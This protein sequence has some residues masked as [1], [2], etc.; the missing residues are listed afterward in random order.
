[1]SSSSA[2]LR[3][4]GIHRNLPTFNESI[5]GLTA[6]ITGANGISGFNTMRALLD[7][8]QRWQTIYGL[9]RRPPPESMMA[10]LS[11]E[12]RSRIKIVTCDFLDGPALI[13]K[14]MKL[15]GVRA[16]YVFYYSY[17]HKDWS[18][19]EALVKSNV[20]LLKNFLEALEVADIRPARFILQTG[21][22]N[23]G[24]Q[25]GRARTPQLESDPQPR[26]L[27]PNFYYPQEDLLKSYCEKQGTSWNVIRPAAVIGASTHAAMNMFYPFAVYAAVQ[28]R[29]G[30]PLFFGGDWEQWQYEYHHCSARMTGYLTEWAA[31]EKHCGNEAFNSN[32]GGPLTYERFFT[33]LASWFGAKGVVPPPD[34]DSKMETIGMGCGGKESPLGYGPPMFG[35]SSFSFLDWANEEENAAAWRDIMMESG[36]KITHDPFEDTESFYM[37]KWAYHR[38]GSVCLNKA[39]R[40]GWTGFVDTM[41]S[42]FE[43]YKEMSKLGTLPPMQ[44]ESA[45][46]LC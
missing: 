42:I 3:Q 19:A 32:D 37:L 33:E 34:D 29:K 39:R 45:H 9:S 14:S 4:V 27:A 1:M 18:E 15:A 10:L 23:Y 24:T 6:I 12:A 7:S 13:A 40:Y 38:F 17:I 21:G 46:P 35:K 8:P 2:Y 22:K 16:D 31:L 11:H 36:G 43:M 25:I 26:H 5:T 30:E 41:E 20:L 44:V 28:A